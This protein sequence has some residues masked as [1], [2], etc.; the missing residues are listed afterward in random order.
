MSHSPAALLGIGYP[1]IGPWSPISW[2]VAFSINAPANLSRNLVFFVWDKHVH[3]LCSVANGDTCIRLERVIET[4]VFL[5]GV[6]FIWYV[7]GL[8]IEA[9]GRGT[10]ARARFGTPARVVVDVVAFLAGSLFVL[11]FVA[12]VRNMHLLRTSWT[13]LG[14]FCYLAWALAMVVPYGHDLIAVSL[15]AGKARRPRRGGRF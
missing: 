4:T 3:P 1:P 12:N 7:V 9:T 14:I 2:E 13:D 8:E 15:A 10:G 11:L 5:L 6:A